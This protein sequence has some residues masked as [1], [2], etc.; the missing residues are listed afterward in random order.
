M[1]VER[2]WEAGNRRIQGKNVGKQ[3]FNYCNESF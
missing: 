2:A 3:N 1:P